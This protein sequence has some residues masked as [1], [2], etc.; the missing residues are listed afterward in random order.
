MM[1]LR[2]IVFHSIEMLSKFDRE[3]RRFQTQA[4]RSNFVLSQALL[5]GIVDVARRF[6]TDLQF[7]CLFLEI[8]RQIEPNLLAY[9]FPLPPPSPLCP[10]ILFQ[11]VNHAMP[12]LPPRSFSTDS[13]PRLSLTY[14]ISAWMRAPCRHLRPTCRCLA[15]DP[16]LK[17]IFLCS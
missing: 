11:A 12:T 2:L 10:S 3:N 9:L 5:T 1:A 4:S 17:G 16:F 6:S 8:G 14:S 15:V 7:A 13:P